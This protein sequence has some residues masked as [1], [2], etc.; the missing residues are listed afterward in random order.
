MNEEKE[1]LSV[2]TALRLMRQDNQILANKLEDAQNKYV[3]A[4][5]EIEPIKDI[6]KSSFN[7]IN[8][9][10][11]QA[12]L[13]M[14]YVA[15]Y[16]MAEDA[17][18]KGE[19]RITRLEK[20]RDIAREEYIK[21]KDYVDKN[22]GSNNL[23][24]QKKLADAQAKWDNL[25]KELSSSYAKRN[26]TAEMLKKTNK[27]EFNKQQDSVENLERLYR[28]NYNTVDDTEVKDFVTTLDIKTELSRIDYCFAA[29][30]QKQK[31]INDSL[32]TFKDVSERLNVELIVDGKNLP[33][34]E[35]KV[36]EKAEVQDVKEKVEEAVE[37]K[38]ESVE[39]KQ[40]EPKAEIEEVKEEEK[41][42]K[43]GLLAGLKGR[44]KVTKERKASISSYIKALLGGS[45]L[46]G[47]VTFAASPLAFA[48]GAAYPAILI[49]GVVASL[50]VAARDIYRKLHNKVEPENLAKL[51]SAQ[52]D[53]EKAQALAEAFQKGI[54][55]IQEAKAQDLTEA[56]QKG[57]QKGIE[58]VQK[59]KVQEVP[60]TMAP[61]P[62]PASQN[63]EAT[64]D[65][66][67]QL[68][69]VIEAQ[70]SLQESVPGSADAKEDLNIRAKYMQD[71]A[72]S[73]SEPE[74]VASMPVR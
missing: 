73:M 45:A 58:D 26:Q 25:N 48:T 47:I 67:Q 37:E 50:G 36:E 30:R 1:R 54:D 31:I 12:G 65:S 19:E 63:V 29:L 40:E 35:K 5:G 33:K 18:K 13:K 71:L 44:H 55:D 74:N 22:L 43:K 41:K 39:V 62:V 6:I 15:S 28:Q 42:S 49:G 72:N 66:L 21:T 20:E 38:P 2:A 4:K 11:E 8:A 32:Y 69:E 52:T 16:E 7:K 60:T 34:E 24:G 68:N 53:E 46:G 59:A 51:D 56:F 64:P 70:R 57:I 61:E 17:F 27:E 14:P 23:E 3:Q 10:Y 9:L